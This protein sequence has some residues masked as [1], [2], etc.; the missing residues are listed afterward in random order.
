MDINFDTKVVDITG[1][2]IHIK[3]ITVTERVTLQN[4]WQ[5]FADTNPP[6]VKVT[7]AFLEA[8]AIGIEK[9]EGFGDKAIVDVL[10]HF[11]D[12]SDVAKVFGHV[13]SYGKLDELLEK[14]SESS[15]AQLPVKLGEEKENVNEEAPSEA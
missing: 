8:L 5:V 10:D 1:T 2:K 14:N 9:I 6:T 3:P 12:M 15:P 11:E 4:A 7:K 13:L